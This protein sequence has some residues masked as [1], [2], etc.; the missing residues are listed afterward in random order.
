MRKS[1][2]QSETMTPEYPILGYAPGN[3][4]NRCTTCSEPFVG[5]KLAHQCEP[6]AK[7]LSWFYKNLTVCRFPMIKE[8]DGPYKEINI[9]INV[10]DEHYNAYAAAVNERG[11][12]YYWFPMSECNENM[13][14]HSMFGALGVLYQAYHADQKVLLHCHAGANRSPTVQAAFYY[15]MIGQHMPDEK[16]GLIYT[17]SNMMAH[18]AGKHLPDKSTME[19]WLQKL[20]TACDHPERFFGGMIEWSFIESNINQL[21]KP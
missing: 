2:N 19:K 12:Q 1:N 8:Y 9:I 16:K 20:R 6:C 5:D 21:Y 4:Q 13:G 11:K 7:F 17:K 18:N 15:L 14:L 10:S 3:Y